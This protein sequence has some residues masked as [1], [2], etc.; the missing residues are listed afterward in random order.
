MSRFGALS[1]E[2]AN[3]ILAKGYVGDKKNPNVTTARIWNQA[4][5]QMETITISSDDKVG[6]KKCVGRPYYKEEHGK[7]RG[8]MIS[9]PKEPQ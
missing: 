1:K 9:F 3:R 6:T 2:W 5:Q 8:N 4:T 7:W